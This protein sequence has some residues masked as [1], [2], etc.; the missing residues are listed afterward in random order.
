MLDIKTPEGLVLAADQSN[1]N[2]GVTHEL[3]GDLEALK[4]VDLDREGLGEYKS[5][6]QKLG[7]CNN[8]NNL[9]SNSTNSISNNCNDNNNGNS[10][11]DNNNN[12]ITAVTPLP[13]S[14]SSTRPS[15]TR[16]SATAS[17]TSLFRESSSS[18]SAHKSSSSSLGT[19][20]PSILKNSNSVTS[21]AIL[22]FEDVF[23]TLNTDAQGTINIDEAARELMKINSRLGKYDDDELRTFINRFR[24]V[25]I[26]SD[27]RVNLKEFKNAFNATL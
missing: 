12:N 23:N 5:Y 15:L 26:N 4:L 19:P 22:S 27:N 6:L 24:A 16:N 3:E 21:F 20:K 8:L 18:F 7:S 11:N 14:R 9:N 2:C 17:R 13:P 1:I 25:S 10:N